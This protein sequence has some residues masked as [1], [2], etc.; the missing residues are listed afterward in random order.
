MTS[1]GG[2]L[3]RPDEEV[4]VLTDPAC[5]EA[6]ESLRSREDTA[7]TLTALACDTS[8]HERGRRSDAAVRLHH[9]TLP[10]LDG[11][12]LVEYDAAERTVS[13]RRLDGVEPLLG[14]FDGGD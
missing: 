3:R 1:Y 6:L 13:Y 7:T 11:A 9:V 8:T 12:G 14:W 5:R 2:L 4:A 10:K